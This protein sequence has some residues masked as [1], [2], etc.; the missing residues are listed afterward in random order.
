MEFEGQNGHID[1]LT[2]YFNIFDGVEKEASFKL[3]DQKDESGQKVNGDIFWTKL[4]GEGHF[5]EGKF[6]C[7]EKSRS[8]RELV[9]FEP[10]FPGDGVILFDGRHAPNL[11]KDGYHIFTARHT[12]LRVG[13]EA[14]KRYLNCQEKGN[15]S[16]ASERES[17]GDFSFEEWRREVLTAIESLGDQFDKIHLIGHSMGAQN[18]FN[19]LII[20]AK[21]RPDLADKISTVISLAGAVGQWR[22]DNTLDPDGNWTKERWQA[23]LKIANERG[24]YK[25]MEIA[26]DLSQV[27]ESY[28]NIYQGDLSAYKHTNFI[29]TSPDS[30]LGGMKDEYNPYSASL[31]FANHLHDQDVKNIAVKKYKSHP[32]EGFEAHDFP[33]FS[34][35]L[36][37][38]W[39]QDGASKE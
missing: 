25:G 28:H 14:A 24:L 19:S 3:R 12:G 8:N 1:G 13:G 2:D 22:E 35:K 37:E 39:I 17:L 11:V 23:G 34:T 20:M 27:E 26:R 16:T 31:E 32:P 18:I 10:G 7:P 21:E 38:H 15:M 29:F 9:I 4:K 5:V 6:F 33:N 30:L 36:L